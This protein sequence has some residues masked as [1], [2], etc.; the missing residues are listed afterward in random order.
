MW[1]AINT[2]VFE[3]DIFQNSTKGNKCEISSVARYKMLASLIRSASWLVKC[4][5]PNH[6]V[7]ELRSATE[8]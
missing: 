5:C 4:Q 3:Y 6:A 8:N 7:A 1:L 2:S